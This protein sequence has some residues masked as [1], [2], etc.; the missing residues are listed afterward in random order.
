MSPSYRKRTPLFRAPC[1][2]PK[3]ATQ[4]AQTAPKVFQNEQPLA[5]SSPFY[6]NRTP[7]FHV[8]RPAHSGNQ[9]TQPQPHPPQRMFYKPRRVPMRGYPDSG[10]EGNRYVSLQQ[11]SGRRRGG[12]RPNTR[13]SLVTPA[14]TPRRQAC[15]PHHEQAPQWCRWQQLLREKHR[16]NSRSCCLFT[17]RQSVTIVAGMVTGES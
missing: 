16:L 9:Q 14:V 11:S 5:P 13:P 6:R 12:Q 8:P 1:A 15:P 7:L 3:T 2:G 10:I 4:S 17:C